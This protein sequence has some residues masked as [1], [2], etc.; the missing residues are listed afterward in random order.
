MSAG[1]GSIESEAVVE[2]GSR[3]HMLQCAPRRFNRTGRL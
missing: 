2:G 1:G 3:S